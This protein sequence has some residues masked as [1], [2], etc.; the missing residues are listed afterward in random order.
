[1]TLSISVFF[2]LI[3]YAGHW[4]QWSD[5]PNSKDGYWVY[6]DNNGQRVENTWI[7]GADRQTWYYIAEYQAMACNIGSYWIGDKVYSFDENGVAYLIEGYGTTNELHKVTSA[8]EGGNVIYIE[9]VE[10]IEEE[11]KFN[12]SANADFNADGSISDSLKNDLWIKTCNIASLQLKYSNTAIFPDYDDSGVLI[13]DSINESTGRIEIYVAGWCQAKNGL[14]NYVEAN[15]T[16]RWV[17]SD[18]G[19]DCEYCYVN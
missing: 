19:Y 5:R 4:E 1:M 13:W 17:E 11:I 12:S 3:S 18:I 10:G 7:E 6:I 2:T 8:P 9:E 15:I 14:G 16:S